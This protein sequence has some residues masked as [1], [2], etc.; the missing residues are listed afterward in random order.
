MSSLVHYDDEGTGCSPAGHLALFVSGAGE[1]QSVQ[2]RSACARCKHMA[3]EFS[4]DEN[5]SEVDDFVCLPSACLTCASADVVDKHSRCLAACHR[6]C[7]VALWT[8]LF[9]FSPFFFNN[10]SEAARDQCMYLS[11]ALAHRE[12]V[13]AVIFCLSQLREQGAAGASGLYRGH[14]IF[15]DARLCTLLESAEVLH[16]DSKCLPTC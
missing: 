13:G 14:P 2:T 16:T 4:E 1:V 9:P 11:P 5:F 8:L 10:L 3:W 6:S 15:V 7:L 12:G